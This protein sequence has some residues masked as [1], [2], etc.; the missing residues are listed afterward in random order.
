MRHIKLFE[1]FIAE[2]NSPFLTDEVE[3]ANKFLSKET[4][5]KIKQ[6]STSRPTLWPA[7]AIGKYRDIEMSIFFTKTV[8]DRPF[9]EDNIEVDSIHH[10]SAARVLKLR[11]PE[12]DKLMKAWARKWG[13]KISN[14]S[15][16][17]EANKTILPKDVRKMIE[18]FGDIITQAYGSDVELGY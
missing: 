13:F 15:D 5:L 11:S 2:F 7:L 1:T 8:L 17:M 4:G 3:K 9:D 18:E 14:S 10:A 6:N 12:A 16:E